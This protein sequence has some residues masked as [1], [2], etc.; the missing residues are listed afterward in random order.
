MMKKVLLIAATFVLILLQ[1]NAQNTINLN[2]HHK[3]A[4]ADFAMD[5]ASKNNMGHDFDVTRLE[6]YISEISIIHD[7][8]NETNIDDL[9]V[10]VKG[11]QQ[12][13]VKLGEHD[14]TSVEKIKI[15]IGVD[16]GHNHLDP[17][18]YSAFH[19]LSPKA[20]SMH[21]G[22]T[23]GYRFVAIE[24]NS[25]SKLNQLFQIH[26]LGDRN[27]FET[28]IDLDITAKDNHINIELDADYTKALEDISI[29]SGLIM[30]GESLQAKQCLENFRDFVFSPS[31]VRSSTND[32]SEV[33]SFNLIPNLVSN[34]STRISL[35]IV[36]HSFNYDV[37]ITSVDGQ[38]LQYL[39]SIVNDQIIDLYDYTSGIY[40]VN[41]LKEGQ[42]VETKRI[43]V[44]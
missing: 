19:P 42:L 39:N 4:D 17:S 21:W 26:S 34:G 6:Y 9:W 15:H 24:G 14:I 11:D 44:K 23:S 5:Q 22:W 38:Q 36:H 20:P 31:S 18:T 29:S 37:S 8:G 10:L 43:F 30:H 1:G 13:G 33:N 3:L 40:L 27:Y 41:L 16:K 35:D 28:V 12:T 2:I 32:F 7:G 25:G